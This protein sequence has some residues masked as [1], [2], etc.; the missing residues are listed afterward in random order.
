[1][2]IPSSSI[3]MGDT[4]YP[5]SAREVGST[6]Y[7][8]SSIEMGDT[9]YPSSAREMGGMTYPRS[10]REM[11][12][13]TYPRCTRE[14]SNT[15]YRSTA[16]DIGGTTYRSCSREV[17]DTTYPKDPSFSCSEIDRRPC[18]QN[19]YETRSYVA[20]NQFRK[21]HENGRQSSSY[22]YG[23]KLPSFDGKEDWKVWI[24]RFEA[25]A[26]RKH[27]DE[28]TKLDNL[29]PRLQGRA[30]DFVF[31]QLPRESLT[32]YAEL[33]KELNSRF[34]VVETKRTFA[35]K[36][37]QRQQRSNETVEE[38]AADLKRLYAKA[39]QGR[40][41]KTR[42]EDL[43]RR[44]LDGL[45]DS[46]A[47][48]EIEYNKEPDDIDEAVY[49]A[50]NFIQTRRRSS[51]EAYVDKKLK[52]YTRRTSEEECYGTDDESVLDSTEDTD[53]VFRVPVKTQKQPT[54]KPSKDEHALGNTEK[55]S[56]APADS[57]QLLTET[58][59]LMQ[60][61][62]TQMSCIANKTNQTTQQ[63]NGQTQRRGIVCYSCNE[64]GHISRDCPN[65]TSKTQTRTGQINSSQGN[66]GKNGEGEMKSN[67]ASRHLN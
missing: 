37:S 39:Y 55:T 31:T 41:S 16:R 35:A 28:G 24:S 67:N 42:Q 63:R 17:G 58:R 1:T 11:G 27:W 60:S 8:S 29:L 47:R 12:G 34:R 9:T 50:V 19:P 51:S 43:V 61:L 15:A 56:T 44:F 13:T 22:G 53:H 23:F 48:F 64:P 21:T 45:K 6:T 57:L 4:T 54:K 18:H 25:I 33:V 10:A 38:F 66:R 20:D 40:D 65:K 26:E 52:R 36:F 49:H 2:T 3:E 7:Q 14:V 32:C 62:M 46:D 30:G 5:R 59:D